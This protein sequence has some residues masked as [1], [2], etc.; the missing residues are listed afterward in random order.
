MLAG[1]FN[2]DP[3]EESAQK[4]LYYEKTMQLHL[5]E[6]RKNPETLLA[7]HDLVSRSQAGQQWPPE[8][9]RRDEYMKQMD[10]ICARHPSSDKE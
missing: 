3:L 7:T 5:V 1:S 9:H 2:P 4:L 8:S 6:L 10:E